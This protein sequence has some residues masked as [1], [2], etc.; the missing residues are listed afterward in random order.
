ME[1]D[2]EVNGPG[3]SYT[4]E[5]RQYDPVVGRWWGVDPLVEEFPWQSPYSPF[6]NNPIK[7]VDPDGR[8]AVDIDVTKNDDG[9]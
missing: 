7:L 6:N 3:R 5:F 2:D 9:T 4:T 1:G 8:A